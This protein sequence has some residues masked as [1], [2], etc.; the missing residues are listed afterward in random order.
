MRKTSAG[1]LTRQEVR[2]PVA[3]ILLEGELVIPMHPVGIVLFAHGSGSSRMS[4]RNRAVADVLH[5]A[6]LATLL[7][8]LLTAE[9]EAVDDVSGRLRFD[10]DLLTRRLIAATDWVA[11]YPDTR[12]L[13]IGYFGASTGAAAALAAAAVRG[14]AVA[15]VVSRGGRPDLAGRWLP[16]VIAPTLLIVGDQDA[17]VVALNRVALAELLGE[18]R[19]EIVPG[20]THLFE[21]AGA[22]EHVARLASDWFARYLPRRAVTG[23]M[24]TPAW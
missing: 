3:G 2:I 19:L 1:E 10:V 20:A 22:L 15:A 17:T 14:D 13:P 16:R 8:D 21:E 7:F 4:P 23:A 6:H 11:H 5:R 18:A 12:L 24:Q 9:E